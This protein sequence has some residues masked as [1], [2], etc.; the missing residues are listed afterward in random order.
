MQPSQIHDEPFLTLKEIAAR[1]GYPY[2]AILRAA[3]A[4]LFPVYAFANGRKRALL[5]EVLAAI[6]GSA[7]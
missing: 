5:S 4:K 3:N 6:K 1:T 7:K 2:Y